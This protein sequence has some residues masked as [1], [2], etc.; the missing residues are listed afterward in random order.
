MVLKPSGLKGSSHGEGVAC[1]ESFKLKASSRR[2]D[3]CGRFTLHTRDRIRLKGLSDLD[4]PFE[5]R[6]N[7]AP[8]QEILAIADY[9]SGPEVRSLVWGL[10]PSR[11][12]DGRA[13]INARAETLEEKASFSDSFRRR[14]CLIPA[15]GFFEWRR[16]GR[17]KQPFYLQLQDE[18][19]FT[20]AG[21]W[22][23]W[24]SGEQLVTSCAIIT[25]AA[26]ELVGQLH[27]RMP[28]MLL[29]ESYDVWLSSKTDPTLLKKLLMPFPARQMKSHPVSS[30]VNYPD[31][32]NY[33]L[34]TRLDAEVGTTPSLF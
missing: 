34:I 20:F 1:G 4:L 2:V 33:Q 8:S 17:S 26:N 6:Y 27:D 28:A 14:R 16:L 25:T 23:R 13:F 9:G 3:M 7:I 18:S 32:D 5:P 11:S 15:D 30:A 29:P 10:M 21:I 24:N 31:N 12:T 22:D 19:P